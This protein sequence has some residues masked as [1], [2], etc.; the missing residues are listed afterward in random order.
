M[1]ILL[2]SRI[3]TF[4]LWGWTTRNNF[5]SDIIIIILLVQPR[6]AES[7]EIVRKGTLEG[8]PAGQ[9]IIISQ[10][11]IDEALILSEMFQLNEICAVELLLAG[12]LL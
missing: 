4:F 2:R 5:P 11:M 3:F 9:K 6:N 7:R 8:I 1:T 10:A 12:M